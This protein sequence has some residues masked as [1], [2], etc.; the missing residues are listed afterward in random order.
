MLIQALVPDPPVQALGIAVLT[1]LARRNV[2]PFDTA[3]LCP[4][5]NGATRELRSVVAHNAQGF[6]VP[7]DKRIKLPNDARAAD[8]GYASDEGRDLLN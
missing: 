1:R 7:V 3:F 4:C 5:Q 8:R 6:A 2:M